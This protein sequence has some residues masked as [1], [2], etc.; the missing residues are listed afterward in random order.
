MPALPRSLRRPIPLPILGAG[1]FLL[2]VLFPCLFLGRVISPADVFTHYTPWSAVAPPTNV[3][4][5]MLNDPPTGWFTSMLAAKRF[6]EGFVWRPFLAGGVPGW[7][8]LSSGLLSP[9]VLFPVL[10]L[11]GSLIFTAIVL[12]RFLVGFGSMYLLL[13]DDG[14]EPAPA[15]VGALLWGGAGAM[16][17]WWLWPH[18]SAAAVFPL[19]LLGVRLAFRPGSRLRRFGPFALATFLVVSAGFPAFAAL[20]AWL[21]LAALLVELSRPESGGRRAGAMAGL[22]VAG[23]VGL[24]PLL[25]SIATFARFLAASG[26]MARR[27]GLA[28]AGPLPLAHLQLLL[29]P[30]AFGSPMEGNPGTVPGMPGVNNFVENCLE[31]GRLALPLAA[32]GL[33]VALA[34]RREATA[35]DRPAPRGPRPWGLLLVAAAVA[36]YTSPGAA[37]AGRLPG[38]STSPLVRLRMVLL[39]ALAGLAAHGTALLLRRLG[40][41]APSL[42]PLLVAAVALEL[43]LFDS[44]FLSYLRP[45]DAVP[46]A[47]S[48]LVRLKDETARSPARLAATFDA[49]WPNSA[50]MA[51][52]E[53]VRSHFQFDAAWRRWL[54]EVDPKVFGEQ[55]TF[56]LL[57][58]LRSRLTS[59]VLDVSGVRW[60]LE[61]PH[62][63]LVAPLAREE[64][65]E[66]AAD[67][68]APPLARLG[69]DRRVE[70][71]FETSGRPLRRV[72]LVLP[73]AGAPVRLS[74]EEEWSGR[75]VWRS[76]G[77]AGP[78]DSRGLAWWPTGDLAATFSRARL[79][80]VVEPAGDREIPLAA[81]SPGEER[82]DE[83]L[84]DGRPAG[85]PLAVALDFGGLA[86]RD[87]VGGVDLRVFERT[88]ALPR[89]WAV[90]DLRAADG[91]D[92]LLPKLREADPRRTAF[93][94]TAQLASL[95]S[96]L[97]PRR[98]VS[99]RFLLLD[100][101]PERLEVEVTLEAP[102]LVV[103]SIRSS[104]PHRALVDGRPAETIETYGLFRGYPL[105]AG[106]HRIELAAGP[107]ARSGRPAYQRPSGSPR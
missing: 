100:D 57:D 19:L 21:S 24:L 30:F 54:E 103:A 65:R 106:T 52:L 14:L 41:R 70:Q 88:S 7:H 16:A 37:L 38:L 3:Q 1:L 5:P 22:A 79:R 97:G 90:R 98:P 18:A 17:V 47:T 104:S 6:P 15:T 12:L 105:P 25:P 27:A 77:A 92:D 68:A 40:P 11:P 4:N 64:Q 101:R 80:L 69:P 36:L 86:R 74:L 53:D 33:A 83:A 60:L 58:G 55:G 72:G 50:E 28:L 29:D 8:Q 73:A 46:R 76:E 32:A 91:L 102:A 49:F 31:T 85:R 95:E 59:P 107:F 84:V 81:G 26:H 94:P 10:L 62:I 42:A 82:W 20:G 75:V 78:L 48:A 63:R 99:A 23:I 56:L 71:P 35:H 39:L 96:T 61:P 34:G 93:V 51:G 67:R 9:L 43:S 89:W 87:D 66:A 44:G 2:V 13:A 45:A